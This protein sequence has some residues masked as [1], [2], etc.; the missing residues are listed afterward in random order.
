M[1]EIVNLR[2]ARKRQDRRSK[3]EKAAGNRVLFG[4]TRAER[5]AIEAERKKG[6]R[7]L[8]AHRL[9]HPDER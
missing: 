7:D 3:A 4:M 5:L 8:D 1:G 9:D 2:Q 6:E